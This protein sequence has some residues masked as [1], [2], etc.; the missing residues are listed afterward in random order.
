MKLTSYILHMKNNSERI[1]YFLKVTWLIG[2]SPG[3]FSSAP[4][5]CPIKPL[6]SGGL[7]V[8]ANIYVE[9]ESKE[10]MAKLLIKGK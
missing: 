6:A 9:P 8:N 2:P 5:P 3:P 1:N 10:N 4:V 7:I